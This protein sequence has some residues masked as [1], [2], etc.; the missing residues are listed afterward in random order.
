MAVWARVELTSSESPCFQGFLSPACADVYLLCV[1]KW[2]LEA[3]QGRLQALVN[4]FDCPVLLHSEAFDDGVA[5]LRVAER[6]V[7]RRGGEQ[8]P[9]GALQ[10]WPI[11]RVA[12]GQDR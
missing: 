4:R 9:V 6:H 1:R 8:A 2:S 7:P 11:P 10:V 12:E 3:R 5:L